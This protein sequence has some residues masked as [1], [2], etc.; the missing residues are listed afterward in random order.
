MGKFI[1][2]GFLE[3]G[4]IG[5]YYLKSRRKKENINYNNYNIFILVVNNFYVVI[6]I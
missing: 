1:E 4:R 3:L 2:R 5:D 6:I